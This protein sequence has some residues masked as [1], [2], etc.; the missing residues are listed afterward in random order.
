MRDYTELKKDLK[1][2]WKPQKPGG[3]WDR[4]FLSEQ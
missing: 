4:A 1:S 3:F 2:S